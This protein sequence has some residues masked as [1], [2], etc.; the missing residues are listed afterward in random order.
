M[1][2]HR[3]L[4]PVEAECREWPG[5]TAAKICASGWSSKAVAEVQAVIQEAPAPVPTVPEVELEVGRDSAGAVRRPRRPARRRP[6]PRRRRARRLPV[7]RKRDRPRSTLDSAA[8]NWAWWPRSWKVCVTSFWAH[9][10][11]PNSSSTSIRRIR[12]KL[13]NSFSYRSRLRNKNHSRYSNREDKSP[14]LEKKNLTSVVLSLFYIH[15]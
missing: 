9:R 12:G 15:I 14:L 13:S 5:S 3:H 7:R 4:R 8:A 6:T 11:A 1:C 10:P 2:R